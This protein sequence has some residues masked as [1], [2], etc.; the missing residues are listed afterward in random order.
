MKSLDTRSALI[1]EAERFIRIQGYAG[2]SYADLSKRIGIRKAS[3]H[4]HFT[5]KEDLGVAVI[6]TYL[7]RFSREL[8]ALASKPVDAAT[9]LSSYGE[10][11]STSLNDGLMPLCGALA[12]DTSALPKSMQRRVKKFFQ[13]HLEWLEETVSDGLRDRMLKSGL[14]ASSTATLLLST[15]Q[16]ASIIAWALKDPSVIK[17]AYTQALA[18]IIR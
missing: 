4:H 7:E 3:V 16:G 18:S 1:D 12:A 17:R 2:F 9:K 8:A 5:T 6:D 13:I 15:L 14:S 11:F 10:F